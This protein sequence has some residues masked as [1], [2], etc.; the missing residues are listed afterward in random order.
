MQTDTVSIARWTAERVRK[1]RGQRTQQ[2]FGALIR[3]PGEEFVYVA[4]GQLIVHTEFYD[5][6]TLHAG[7][8]IY[9]DSNMGHGY[10][11]AANS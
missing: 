3:H 5:P 2:E 1:L 4:E 8:G 10:I 11:A 7:E 9:I 6:V